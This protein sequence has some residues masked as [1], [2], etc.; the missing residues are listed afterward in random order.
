MAVFILKYQSTGNKFYKFSVPQHII[1]SPLTLAAELSL[2]RTKK[3][4]CVLSKTE[5]P[6]L[7]DIVNFDR[8]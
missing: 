6:E 7:N 8:N 1:H 2:R 5:T 3:I 4:K